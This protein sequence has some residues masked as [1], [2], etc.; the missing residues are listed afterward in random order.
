M[1]AGEDVLGGLVFHQA[2]S[3]LLHGHLRQRQV[4]VQGRDRSLGHDPINLALVKLFKGAQSRL[5]ADDQGINL[6]AGH[7]ITVRPAFFPASCR[8]LY[9]MLMLL[10][11]RS[12]HD[13]GPPHVPRM[14]VSTADSLRPC[15][16]TKD[17]RHN[18]TKVT[19]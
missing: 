5:C 17:I 19:I 15:R 9:L 4:L 11:L 7:L 10:L 18:V 12:S 14:P 1:L 6:P 3:G 8:L 2:A 16:P 13:I